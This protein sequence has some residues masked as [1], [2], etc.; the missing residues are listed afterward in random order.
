[1]VALLRTL[2]FFVL[3]WCHQIM[4]LPLLCWRMFQAKRHSGPFIWDRVASQSLFWGRLT[5]RLGGVRVTV[6]DH[7]G[8]DPEQTVLLVSNHQGDFDIPVLLGYSGR[9]LAFVAK[10]ELANIPS[11]SQWMGL[12]G[13][14]FL[15]REDRRKQVRQIRQTVE[16]LQQGLSMV[17]FPEGTR[18]RGGPMRPF[19]AGS[20]NIAEKA[21]VPILPVTL[22]D[23]YKVL[24]KGKFLLQGTSVKMILHPAVQ[25]NELT[26]EEKRNLHTRVRDIVASGL[27]D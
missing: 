22:V 21:G 2:T 11:V 8:L 3:F 12:M 23:T 17:I 24:P 18:S 5:C 13:C 9:K 16:Q 6:E 20:L 7:S 15:D 26:K 1:M 14:I 4:I 10:K 25:T 19:A 27:P